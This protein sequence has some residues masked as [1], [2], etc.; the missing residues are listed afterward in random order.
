MSKIVNSCSEFDLDIFN[1]QLCNCKGVC[2]C[3]RVLQDNFE[4]ENINSRFLYLVDVTMAVPGMSISAVTF[5]Q[6]PFKH[7]MPAI[8][9][10]FVSNS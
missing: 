5:A 2:W 3:F 9:E 4:I 1:L 6:T 8:T 7:F 10:S